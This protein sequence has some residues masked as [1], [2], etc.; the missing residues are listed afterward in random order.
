M[1]LLVI[2]ISSGLDIDVI[3]AEVQYEV[4][5]T[6]RS[7]DGLYELTLPSVCHAK[8]IIAILPTVKYNLLSSVFIHFR[9]LQ[10]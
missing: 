2:A 5:I 10:V 9:I 8:D 1:I 7:C 4:R 6:G 3:L